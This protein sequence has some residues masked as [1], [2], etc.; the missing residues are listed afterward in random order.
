[1]TGE[2]ADYIRRMVDAELQCE[3]FLPS[4]D[5]SCPARVTPPGQDGA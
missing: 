4:H 5:E 1:M 3:C 2:I